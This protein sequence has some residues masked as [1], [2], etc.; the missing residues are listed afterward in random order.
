[1]RSLCLIFVLPTLAAITVS[2][3]LFTADDFANHPAANTSL[4]TFRDI[5]KTMHQGK[6]FSTFHGYVH[7]LSVAIQLINAS[8]ILEIGSYCGASVALMLGEPLVKTLVS[9][10]IAQPACRGVLAQNI[11]KFN[12]FNTDV[13]QITGNSRESHIQQQVFSIFEANSVD[14]IFIDGDHFYPRPDFELYQHLLRPGGFLVW[15]D[16]G[17][18][19]NVI[20]HVNDISKDNNGCYHSIGT[21]RNIAKANNFPSADQSEADVGPPMDLSNEFIM[22][23]RFN[24]TE[25]WPI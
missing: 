3:H 8:K 13:K 21:P 10:D 7:I 12:V 2:E 20:A 17:H 14:I 23:K 16:Y 25:W 11:V 9:V 19:K 15:D 1:M 22:Q 4:A 5:R 6:Q 24:C 18:H